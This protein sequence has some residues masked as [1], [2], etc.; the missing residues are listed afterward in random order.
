MTPDNLGSIL[1]S[2]SAGELQ[3]AMPR[4]VLN[5]L[6]E[7]MSRTLSAALRTILTG[8]IFATCLMV[9]LHYM[10]A[11]VPSPYQLLHDLAAIT[12]LSRILS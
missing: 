11:P 1:T 8:A 10:G 12:R 4:K 2:Y 7:I 9:T 5:V 3:I 6:S